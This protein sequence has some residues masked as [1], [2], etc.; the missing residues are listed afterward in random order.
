MGLDPPT[1]ILNGCVLLIAHDAVAPSIPRHRSCE[2]TNGSCGHHVPGHCPPLPKE[3]WIISSTTNIVMIRSPLLFILGSLPAV[4]LAQCQV[5]SFN[6]S[7]EFCDGIHVSLDLSG[8][9]A[10]YQLTFTGS[11]GISE[12]RQ[13]VPNGVYTTDIGDL[14]VSI[15]A[16]PVT[17]TVVDA[18]GC[19]TS[20]SAAYDMHAYCAPDVWTERACDATTGTLLWSGTYSYWTLASNGYMDGRPD[21]CGSA[22][23][24]YII[25]NSQN[26]SE[27]QSGDLASDWTQL[28]NGFFQF[29]GILPD[30]GYYV[31]IFPLDPFAHGC[32]NGQVAYCYTAHGLISDPNVCGQ[33]FKLRVLLGGPLSPTAQLMTDGLRTNG[34]IPL[35]EP[36]SALGYTYAGSSGGHTIPASWLS[37]TGAN[38]LVDW[39]V[40]ELRAAAAPYEVLYSMPAVVQR[41]GDVVGMEGSTSLHAPLAP[42]AY[43]ISVHHRNHLGAMT[44]EAHWLNF[45]PLELQGYTTVDLRSASL[46]MYG[47]E[48]RRPNGSVLCL[49]PGD[50]TRNGE[51]KY[52]GEDNDRDLVLQGIGGVVPTNVVN[53]VYDARDVNLDGAIK[54]AGTDNDRDVILQTIG[55]LVPTATRNQ[56]LP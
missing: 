42:G 2:G 16:S 34:L 6:V 55:G 43:R 18:G 36:Y 10:P 32:V 53:G 9:Q 22:P 11:N 44:A 12:L 14:V 25:T 39:I 26:W 20:A 19:T 33:Q 51:V 52:A 35:T 56:Q 48:A 40:V 8:G 3:R 17:V 27:V 15:F 23:Y 37:T 30:G 7:A 24:V 13:G 49:W 1:T 41:D 38:A 46:P 54:Y 21:P 47:T 4:M 28:P 5:N 50:A 29:N 31:E 45:S